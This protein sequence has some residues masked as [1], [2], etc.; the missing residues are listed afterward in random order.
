M[1]YPYDLVTGLRPEYQIPSH[2][3]VSHP[4]IEP[5]SLAEI[6]RHLRID[7]DMTEDDEDLDGLI[8]AG[9]QHVERFTG[10]AL[11]DQTFEVSLDAYPVSGVIRLKAPLLS[12][13]TFEY[14][15]DDGLYVALDDSEYVL[16]TLYREPR[17]VTAYGVTWPTTI[18]ASNSV[19]IRYRAGFADRTGSPTE[20]P[21]LV[22]G[23]LKTAIKLH[24]EAYYDRDERMMEKLLAACDNLCRPYCVDYGVA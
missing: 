17:L 18:A 23:P 14:S 13:A 8:T 22:P 11:I 15:D 9:R 19:R 10:L 4:D 5:V 6:K 24:A 20:G 16:D 7:E 12:V 3:V 1:T 2:V 21:E